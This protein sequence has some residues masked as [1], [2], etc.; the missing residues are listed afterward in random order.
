MIPVAKAG[1]AEATIARQPTIITMVSRRI[2]FRISLASLHE[3]MYR[4]YSRLTSTRSP[5]VTGS[6]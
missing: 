3:S 5:S 4:R 1:T 6:M 2:T